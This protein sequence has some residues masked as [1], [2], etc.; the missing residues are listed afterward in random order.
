M[1]GWSVR[2]LSVFALAAILAGLSVL[3]GR[4]SAQAAPG[5]AAIRMNTAPNLAGTTF[6]GNLVSVTATSPTDAWAV[7]GKC[8]TS[9][10]HTIHP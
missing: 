2:A 5:A 3:P 10:C 7:G 1:S 4:Q 6:S 9:Q 8:A